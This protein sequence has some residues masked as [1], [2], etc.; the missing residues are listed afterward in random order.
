M[1]TKYERFVRVKIVVSGV[2]LIS[3]Q[4]LCEGI[5]VVAVVC[6]LLTSCSVVHM[7][8]SATNQP[9]NKC[10]LV[11][12]M[13]KYHLF[14]SSAIQ[15]ESDTREFVSGTRQYFNHSLGGKR[16]HQRFNDVRDFFSGQIQPTQLEAKTL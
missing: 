13:W 14:T 4:C 1:A 5:S 6:Y 7:T 15:S 16:K 3:W 12:V 2:G 9:R 8:N 11:V 10:S